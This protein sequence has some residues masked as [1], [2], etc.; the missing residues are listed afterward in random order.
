MTRLGTV[1][2]DH[3][4]AAARLRAQPG[5]WLP[6]GEYRTQGTANAAAKAIRTGRWPN[7]NPAPYTV[8]EFEPRTELTEFGVRVLARHLGT[9]QQRD[10]DA[11]NARYPVGT[12]VVA[13]PGFRPEDDRNARRIETT[14]RSRAQVLSGHTAVVWVHDHSACIALTHI[15][16]QPNPTAEEASS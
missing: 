3:R 12:P 10:V 9:Q 7:G 14:T 13:Y 5:V 16:P 15:D 2:I 8:G 1:Q 6:V 4:D 11:F